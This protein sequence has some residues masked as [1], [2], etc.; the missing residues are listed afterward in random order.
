MYSRPKPGETEEDLLRQQKEYFEKKAANSIKP[1][2]KFVSEK[3][4]YKYEMQQVL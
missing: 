3:S 4:E 1:A 2:A